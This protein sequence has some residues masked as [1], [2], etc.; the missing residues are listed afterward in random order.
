M[1][2]FYRYG[3]VE[4]IGK[5]TCPKPQSYGGFQP[6]ILTPQT[7]KCLT[8]TFLTLKENIIK[9]NLSIIHVFLPSLR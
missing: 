5:E 4:E 3:I 9:D 2:P 7:H 6:A 1:S 8:S